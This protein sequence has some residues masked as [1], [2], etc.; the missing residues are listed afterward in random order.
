[1]P[2][3]R[4][5]IRPIPPERQADRSW[6]VRIDDREIASV[7]SVVIASDRFGTLTYGL[8]QAGYDGWSFREAGG[9]V[10]ILPYVWH[11]DELWVGLVRQ[12]RPNQGGLVLNAPRGF[13]APHESHAAGA[14]R[15]F[16]EETGMRCAADRI[17]ALGGE[18]A[19]PNSA[20]FETVRAGQGVH[21]YAVGLTS[22]DVEVLPAGLRV[23]S[24]LI[25]RD[26]VSAKAWPEQIVD[27]VLVPWWE[28][29]TISDMFTNAA[30][31]R[32]CAF[33]HRRREVMVH[34]GRGAEAGAGAN[35]AAARAAATTSWPTP[36][37]M[38][39]PDIGTP[40]KSWTPARSSSPIRG[41]MRS[42]CARRRP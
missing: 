22:D 11:G 27:T 25:S 21:F 30:V 24:H 4:S 28:A 15:E 1:M 37:R 29:A 10:V 23:R 38:P 16:A 26:A 14:A 40:A 33:L 19:N 34:P 13:V 35:G 8:T 42:T 7:A 17:A 20:F 41:S 39:S 31:A 6:N 32:L 3:E 9:G 2:A 36:R 5:L 18:P 12:D